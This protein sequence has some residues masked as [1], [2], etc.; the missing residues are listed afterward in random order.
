[1]FDKKGKSISTTTNTIKCNNGVM[2]MNMKMMMP[3]Q[4]QQPPAEAQVTAEGSYMDYPSSM[5]VGETLK[6]AELSLD[7]SNNGMKQSILMNITNRKIEGKAAFK[8]EGSVSNEVSSNVAEK[9]GGNYAMEV[10]GSYSLKANTIVLEAQ[11]GLTI[12]VGGNF[13]TINAAGVQINGTLVLI[14]SGGSAGSGSGSSPTAPTAAEKK[15]PT[16][17]DDS[18]SGSKSAQ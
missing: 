3:Q 9:V 5:S 13:V 12:K 11:S 8:T 6:D 10:T 2:M 1:M 4:Q 15:E 18:A 7:M 17:A 14:N 16:E